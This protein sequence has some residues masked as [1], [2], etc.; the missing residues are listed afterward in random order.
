MDKQNDDNLS[1][2]GIISN[3]IIDDF[4]IE[5]DLILFEE[6]RIS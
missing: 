6:S 3:N 1:L 4:K 2:T 5:N